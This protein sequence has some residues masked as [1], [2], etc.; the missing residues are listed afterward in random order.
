MI[1]LAS[2][3]LF[4]LVISMVTFAATGFKYEPDSHTLGLWH[5]DEGSGNVVIDSSKNNIQAVINGGARWNTNA[6]WNKEDS[7]NSF[8]FD[9]QRYVTIPVEDKATRLEVNLTVTVCVSDT[10]PTLTLT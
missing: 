6:R 4:L 2:F 5:F 7:G 1:R 8:V 9:E 10:S 3:T